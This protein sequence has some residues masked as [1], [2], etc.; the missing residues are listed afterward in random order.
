MSVFVRGNV[1]TITAAFA[2]LDGSATQPS[3]VTAQVNYKDL[4]GFK[5]VDDVPLSYQST[6]N[7]WIGTWDSSVAGSCTAA[8]VAKGIGSLQASAQ[9]EFQIIAN[10]ANTN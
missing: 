10:P 5:H 9:G 8:W 1:L 7:N 6:P 3:T 4:A 2:A